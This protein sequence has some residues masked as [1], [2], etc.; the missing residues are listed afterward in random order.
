MSDAYSVTICAPGTLVGATVSALVYTTLVTTGELAASATGA[1]I[2]LTGNALAY[3]TELVAGSAAGTT[4]RTMAKTYGAIAK[5]AISNGSRLG[6]LG[7]SVLAGAGAAVGTSALLYGGKCAGQYIYDYYLTAKNKLVENIKIEDYIASKIQKPVESHSE[8]L[9]IE[10]DIQLI[11][12]VTN[13]E[14]KPIVPIA[15]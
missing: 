13:V 11:Q 5:P 14:M 1:G 6:A 15:L 3:G 4:V 7:I 10:D 2:E 12:D 9:L 8:V